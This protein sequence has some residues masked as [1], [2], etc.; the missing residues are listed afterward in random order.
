MQKSPIL[1]V[2]VL[3]LL[4]LATWAV[5]RSL[6]PVASS[7]QT[8]PPIETPVGSA[9]DMSEASVG[10]HTDPETLADLLERTKAIPPPQQAQATRDLPFLLQ[11]VS[12][13][14]IKPVANA[15]VFF[16]R[17]APER[18]AS[19]YAAARV[20]VG[21]DPSALAKPEDIFHTDA[22]GHVNLP[23]PAVQTQIIA[24][25]DS[26]YG[27]LFGAASKQALGLGQVAHTLPIHEDPLFTITVRDT[28]GTLVAAK[29]VALFR[30][31]QTSW[32][33]SLFAQTNEHGVA[34]FF[35]L[36][37]HQF[38]RVDGEYGFGFDTPGLAPAIGPLAFEDLPRNAEL[39]STQASC[40]KVHFF[41]RFGDAYK[42]N[43]WV[44][45][46]P[47]STPFQ[48]WHNRDLTP[49]GGST[50]EFPEVE[51]GTTFDLKVGWEGQGSRIYP[52]NG[53][54]QPGETVEV[55]I[56]SEQ[57]RAILPVRLVAAD[58]HVFPNVA[59]DLKLEVRERKVRKVRSYP[60]R[61]NLTGETVV[62]F[63]LAKRSSSRRASTADYVAVF[64]CKDPQSGILLQGE[65]NLGPSPDP[66]THEQ[67]DIVLKAA[68]ILA[69]GYVRSA[70]GQP[71]VNALVTYGMVETHTDSK[72]HFV[73]NTPVKPPF[74][75]LSVSWRQRR[76]RRVPFTFGAEDLEIILENRDYLV[77]GKLS[78]PEELRKQSFNLRFISEQEPRQV[79]FVSIPRGQTSFSLELLTDQPGRL[80]LLTESGS[81]LIA[82]M[83]NLQPA[84]K[85]DVQD[86]RLR[87][88]LLRDQIAFAE[89][90]V[91]MIGEAVDSFRL[92]DDSPGYRRMFTEVQL[93]D[94]VLYVLPN[95]KPALASLDGGRYSEQDFRATSFLLKPGLQ[96]VHVEP[97]ITIFFAFAEK[98]KLPPYASIYVNLVNADG[99]KK[100]CE[101]RDAFEEE[102]D[103]FG[104]DAIRPKLTFQRAGVWSLTAKLSGTDA[105]G[106]KHTIP[107]PIGDFADGVLPLSVQESSTGK[108]ILLDITQE[109][110]NAV[111]KKAGWVFK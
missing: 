96:V 86:E 45:L 78:L 61:T 101:Y 82:S 23:A 106:T 68:P 108:E 24:R 39:T 7:A 70:A 85:S 60:S 3:A 27:Q 53:P 6:G 64:S 29:S 49:N 104:A 83:H 107:L 95:G 79:S 109:D 94:R 17:N 22:D 84:T 40:L 56:T 13:D 91:Q 98:Y 2:A 9:A 12:K 20:N 69:A 19:A 31:S 62:V 55:N 93:G 74:K 34:T 44:Q 92:I 11:V 88:W 48:S 72:G 37:S 14:G 41:D 5:I 33:A 102:I 26:R 30:K 100:W 25:S 75:T 8:K 90:E 89:I 1:P 105:G 57:E 80:Q 42:G 10:A 81:H 99:E 71:A 21:T 76:I 50:I 73:M 63:P 66:I 67:V 87:P 46:M 97:A 35:G 32:T 18:F 65:L 58:G 15:E 110:L 103:E 28:D 54:A 52:I 38:Y 77:E 51:P 4:L 59:V 47:T 43:A 111:F 16:I 36:R